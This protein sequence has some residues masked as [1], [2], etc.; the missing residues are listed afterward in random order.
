MIPRRLAFACPNYHPRICGVADFSDHLAQELGG[1]G[2]E[3]TIHSPVPA[4]PNPRRPDIAVVGHADDG[5]MS[6][7]RSIC[8]AVLAMP[9]E[10][11]VVQY[12]PQMWG[13]W[14][15]GSPAVPWLVHEVRKA[16]IPVYVVGH[17]LYFPWSL[18][19]DLVVASMLLRVQ[20]GALLESSDRV[21]VTTETRLRPLLAYCRALGL[22]EPGIVRVGANALPRV[23]RSGQS[24]I[25]MGVF[26]SAAADK[27][28]DILLDAFAWIAR[29]RPDAQ[30]VLIGDLGPTDRPGV[31]AV[32]EAVRRHPAA[33][34]IRMTGRLE[35]DVVTREI[36]SLDVYICTME[37]GAN[38]RS[39]TLPS[40]LGSG[41][42]VVAIEGTETDSSIFRDR[43]T[44][45]F[46]RELTGPA[47]ATAA[48]EILGS[49][50]LAARLSE[51]ARAV[52]EQHLAWPKIADQL[53]AQIGVA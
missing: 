9:P 20:L 40:A 39:S 8:R 48:L 5:P 3:V 51:G 30:L 46:A 12:T 31:R 50:A 10:R 45:L 4:E 38:T 52:Y 32:F 33:A 27:R 44:I 25:R 18:R 11:L 29:A 36:E 35:L 42:P 1:R 16:G 15:F 24:G 14:R 13:A 37:T 28:F 47:F 21:M 19:P 41:I 2:F 17:E 34:Q 7:A 23:R 43:E 22:P 53:L 6:V 49:P 26:S